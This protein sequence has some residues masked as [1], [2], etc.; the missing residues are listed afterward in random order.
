MPTILFQVL[1]WAN[2]GPHYLRVQAFFG[3]EETFYSPSS[4]LFV[5]T[6]ALVLKYFLA[7]RSHTA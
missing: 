7:M 1:R 4:V 5:S 6:V 2:V 3:S